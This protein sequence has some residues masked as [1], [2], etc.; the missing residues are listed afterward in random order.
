MPLFGTAPFETDVVFALAISWLNGEFMNDDYH[1]ID[2]A[3]AA[4]VP[5]GGSLGCPQ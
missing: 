5:G 1:R 3:A 2:M 4:P